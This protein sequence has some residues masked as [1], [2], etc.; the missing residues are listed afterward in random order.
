MHFSFRHYAAS[1]D[2]IE[3]DKLLMQGRISDI[4]NR[5]KKVILVDGEDMEV[6]DMV[7]RVSQFLGYFLLKV[8]WAKPA[9]FAQTTYQD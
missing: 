5:F 4:M 7:S 8:Y 3:K 9:L 6:E 2:D 1:K